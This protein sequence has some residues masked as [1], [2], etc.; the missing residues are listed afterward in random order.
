MVSVIPPLMT[1]YF[2]LTINRA[3]WCYITI[4]RSIG[5]LDYRNVMLSIGQSFNSQVQQLWQQFM[6]RRRWSRKLLVLLLSCFLLACWIHQSSLFAS[7]SNH[8]YVSWS[9]HQSGFDKGDGPYEELELKGFSNSGNAEAASCS[10]LLHTG[11]V[12]VQRSFE[13]DADLVE[14]AQKLDRMPMVD[15]EGQDTSLTFEQTVAQTWDRFCQSSVWLPQYKVFLAVTRVIFYTKGTR[16]WPII[17]FLSGQIYDQD[18]VEQKDFVI[19]W[20]GRKVSFP[21]VFDIPSPYA[22]GGFAYGP[23]DPRI[24]LEADVPD[25]EPVILFNMAVDID[26]LQS[27]SM[28]AFRPFSNTTVRLY[29]TGH[30]GKYEV[31]KNWMPFFYSNETLDRRRGPSDELHVVYDIRPLRILKC[32]LDS[33]SCKP[34]YLQYMKDELHRKPKEDVGFLG[35]GTN[36]EPV[37]LGPNSSGLQAY[38]GFP[39]S[40]TSVGCTTDSIY[41]PELMIM[42]VEAGRFHIMYLSQPTDFGTA[43]LSQAAVDDPCGEGRILIANSI[44]RW[45]QQNDIMT[46]TISVDDATTQV[47]RLKGV[48]KHIQSLTGLRDRAL[49]SPLSNKGQDVDDEILYEDLQWSYVG[50][51]VWACC[52]ESAAEHARAIAE[53]VNGTSII[54]AAAKDKVAKFRD[55][56][57]RENRHRDVLLGKILADVPPIEAV[58]S[59]DLEGVDGSGEDY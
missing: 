12:S 48:L 31:E 3:R 18:W 40:H 2:H 29:Q 55:L 52:L 41:R 54:A 49:L 24:V 5:A 9:S 34:V 13:R 59:E 44:A 10:S 1:Y 17:S 46:L 56:N 14:I 15:Y 53:P 27:R 35:G 30:F 38:I 6:H 57:D 43:V 19:D 32:N 7:G 25:A 37:K 4:F 39:R 50:N 22:L 51:E 16:T 20:K 58:G 11:S 45:D 21:C 42:T 33:G 28:H 36:L 47:V 8:E 26:T 23:E